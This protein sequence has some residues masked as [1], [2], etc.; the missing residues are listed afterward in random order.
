M[1]NSTFD[2]NSWAKEQNRQPGQHANYY[3]SEQTPTGSRTYQDPFYTSPEHMKSVMGGFAKPTE[4]G[5]T[6]WSSANPN[7]VFY[8]PTGSDW[9]QVTEGMLSDPKI[10]QTIMGRSMSG[11]AAGAFGALRDKIPAN[12]RQ[13]IQGSTNSLAPEVLAKM[14]K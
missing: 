4:A 14:W 6:R 13:G 7:D 2:Y 10:A 5:E 1:A 11:P 9:Q 3:L 8:S 12:V